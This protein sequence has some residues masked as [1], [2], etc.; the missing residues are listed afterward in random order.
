MYVQLSHPAI[1]VSNVFSSSIHLCCADECP[2][3]EVWTF[4]IPPFTTLTFLTELTAHPSL[5]ENL[6]FPWMALG[7]NWL[8]VVKRKQ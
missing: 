2:N 3:T 5:V 1:P 8:H 4:E 7:Q 6:D